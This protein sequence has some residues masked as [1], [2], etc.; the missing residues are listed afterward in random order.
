MRLPGPAPR[1]ADRAHYAMFGAL[2]RLAHMDASAW[3]YGDDRPREPR[4]GG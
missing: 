2:R 4:G 3:A 1:P